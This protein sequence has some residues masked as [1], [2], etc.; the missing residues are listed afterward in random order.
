MSKW[1]AAAI[2]A[3]FAAG[4]SQGAAPKHEL[5]EAQRDSVLGRSDLP[6]ASAVGRAMQASDKEAHHAA[7]LNAAV[8]SLPK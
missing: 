1:I 5:T 8:D 7:D 2:L 4:C 3:M 6:G